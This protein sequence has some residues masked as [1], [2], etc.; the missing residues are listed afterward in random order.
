MQDS[1]YL[2]KDAKD[3]ARASSSSRDSGSDESDD[4]W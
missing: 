4:H 1:E 3:S 2:T